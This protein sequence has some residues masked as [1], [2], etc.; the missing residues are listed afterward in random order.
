MWTWH[1]DL[2]GFSRLQTARIKRRWAGHVAE[3]T[4]KPWA[5]MGISR[6][7]YYRR[8]AREQDNGQEDIMQAA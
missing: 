3:S 1:F 7:T 4:T 6:A 8:K 5:A 2:D